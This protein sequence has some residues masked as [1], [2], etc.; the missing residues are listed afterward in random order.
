MHPYQPPAAP[1]PR[2]PRQTSAGMIALG[3]ALATV[4]AIRFGVITYAVDLET[5]DTRP[6]IGSAHAWRPRCR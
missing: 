5:G 3:A 4:V 6:T 2:A 1:P